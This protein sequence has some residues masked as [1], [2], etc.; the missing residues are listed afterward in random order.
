MIQLVGAGACIALLP[1]A[2]SLKNK[3]TAVAA[4]SLLMF[5]TGVFQGPMAP[6]K[7]ELGRDWMK[8]GVERAWAARFN[9][10]SHSACPLLAA[11]IT[12]RISERFGWRVVCYVYAAAIGVFAGLWQL[13]ATD[14]PAFVDGVPGVW[15]D[16]SPAAQ[17]AVKQKEA[18]RAALAAT[19]A[20]SGGTAG[21]AV[22]KGSF[23]WRIL[24]AKPSLALGIFHTCNDILVFTQVKETSSVRHFILK[25]I[26]LP[27]Q[28]QDKLRRKCK[29]RVFSRRQCSPRRCIW[30]SLAARRWRWGHTWRLAAPCTSLQVRGESLLCAILHLKTKHL[31]RQAPDKHRGPPR[32]SNN[33]FTHRVCVGHHRV[34]HDQKKDTHPYD[35]PDVRRR[36]S[37]CE[38]SLWRALR[39]RSEPSALHD[40]LRR[41]RCVQCHAHIGRLVELSGG[42]RRG[43]RDAK[44]L[45]EH[46]R[47]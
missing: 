9:S 40:L 37:L 14:R 22:A 43:H 35:P 27:R 32:P 13:L 12:T 3:T 28:A 26:S 18:D 44:Q 36:G 45:L 4:M 20:Q 7:S 24:W 46:A 25:L 1:T 29:N 16:D 10:I 33:C 39:I 42:G 23:D 11:L 19:Q 41:H 38:R 17:A 47:F 15:A 34:N 21:A 2:G 31:P 6:V 5:L 8:V 30:R